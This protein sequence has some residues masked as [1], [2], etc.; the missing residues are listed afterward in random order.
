MTGAQEQRFTVRRGVGSGDEGALNTKVN[1]DFILES[2]GATEDAE[3]GETR[4]PGQWDDHSHSPPRGGMTPQW[5][6]SP[7]LEPLW[8]S[9]PSAVILGQ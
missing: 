6:S 5:G 1:E 9:A 3:Q 2:V 7:V 8:A 4:W